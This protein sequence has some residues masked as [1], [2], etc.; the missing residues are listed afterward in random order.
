MGLIQESE[1]RGFPGGAVVESPPASAV[2]T[3][4]NP[5]PGRS[6]MPRSSWARAPQLLGLRS[7]AH[8]PQ[9]MKPACLEPVLRGRRGRGNEKPTHRSEG[10]PALAATGEGPRAAMRTQRSR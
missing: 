7:G 2:D 4:S 10:C 8:G 6:H 3:G 5:G 1:L 9:L